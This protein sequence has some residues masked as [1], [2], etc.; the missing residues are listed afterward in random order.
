M[1]GRWFPAD[2]WQ[3]SIWSTFVHG[4]AAVQFN[5]RMWAYGLVVAGLGLAFAAFRRRSRAAPLRPPAVALAALLLIQVS[6]GIAAL[7]YNVP[8]ILALLH[9]FTAVTIL[10]VA[11]LIAWRARRL[12]G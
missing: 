1:G 4:Q 3:G 9:Q 11:T 2:Y 7:I 5:H 10:A 12:V 8:L 6:L